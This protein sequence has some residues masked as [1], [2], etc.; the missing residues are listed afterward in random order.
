MVMEDATGKTI[1][2]GIQPSGS[3]HLGNYLGAL[4]Q[5]VK[6]AENNTCFF[7]IVDEHAI[8]VPYEPAE[9][10]ERVLNAAAL[11]M[12]AGINP[13]RSTIFVQSHVSAHTE[14][15][16]LLMT[17]TPYGDLSRM[18]QF[19]DK[20]KKQQTNTSAGLFG[21]PTLMAADILLYNTDV[22]PVGD[23]QV[24]HIELTRDTAKR[25]NNKFGETFTVPEAHVNANV[26]RIMSLADPAKKMS[27]SDAPKSY[28]A[29]T[30]SPEDIKGKIMS[31]V[32]E[33]DP[34]FS[35]EK[36]GPAVKNLLA[37]YQA[38]SEE[39]PAAIEEKF[40]GKGYKEFKESLAQ[41]IIEKLT[42][43]RETYTTLRQSDDEL[44][45]M[46]GRGKH[47]AEVRANATLARVKEKM[48][49]L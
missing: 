3:M 42:P 30:D 27:K 1:F 32:T 8:T 38:M 23:D 31:A 4:K 9:L 34:V 24:Q 47:H 21:Y 25:F 7:C 6:L 45:I 22:V 28:I 5:W 14:L 44:R 18:T 17:I 16:W 29:L 41:V 11:Y 33:T 35:F 43:L 39:A 48:G 49:L 15:A 19:K 46:L 36:S 10:P 2:S 20:S 13:D 40:V 37:I 12:A 26:A